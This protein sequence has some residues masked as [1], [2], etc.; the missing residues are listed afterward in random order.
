MRVIRG[1][2][3]DHPVEPLAKLVQT[4]LDALGW[5]PTG[6]EV[7]RVTGLSRQYLSQLLKRQEPYRSSPTVAKQQQLAKIPGLTIE[8]IVSAI[9][10]S[11]GVTIPTIEEERGQSQARRSVHSVVDD[12]PEEALPG[13]L[14]MLVD[15]LSN[16]RQRGD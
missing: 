9:N 12:L 5:R 10:E 4:K 6:P 13:V 8:M 7:T 1:D 3:H 14:Q 16:W 15:I 11:R 2:A